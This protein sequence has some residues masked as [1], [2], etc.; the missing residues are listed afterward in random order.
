MWKK[1]RNNKQPV[2]MGESETGGGGNKKQSTFY[3]GW[4]V[5]EE[6]WSGV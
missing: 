5:E 6:G 1:N 3:R 2:E 4:E